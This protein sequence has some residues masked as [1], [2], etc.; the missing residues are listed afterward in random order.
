MTL[1][2][3]GTL[4]GPVDFMFVTDDFE[5]LGSSACVDTFEGSGLATATKDS[6]GPGA[7]P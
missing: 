6:V 7:T 5:G 2:G 1:S 3:N 4:A